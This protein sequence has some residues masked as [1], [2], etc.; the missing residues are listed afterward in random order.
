MDVA[1]V[2]NRYGRSGGLY[3]KPDYLDDLALDANRVYRLELVV[4][5]R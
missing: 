1:Q 5:L 4:I 3:D 2:A